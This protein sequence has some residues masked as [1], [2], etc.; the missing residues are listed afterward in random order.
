M[1]PHLYLEKSQDEGFDLQ[2]RRV[3]GREGVGLPFEFR[4]SAFSSSNV[5]SSQVLG[6]GATLVWESGFGSRALPGY[7]TRFSRRATADASAGRHY[8]LLFEP[9]L[10]NLRYTRR[11]RI[12]QKESIP[13][14]INEVLQP[15][16]ETAIEVKFDLKE[17]HE[18]EVYLVQYQETD[19]NFLS[20]ICREAAIYYEFQSREEDGTLKF[21]LVF[22]DRSAVTPLSIEDIYVSDA[23][24][25]ETQ[26]CIRHL[27]LSGVRRPGKVVA[28]AYVPENPRFAVE[29]E[30]R[31]DDASDLEKETRVYAPSQK[32]ADDHLGQL[33][34]QWLLRRKRARSRCLECETNQPMFAPGVAFSCGSSDTSA[35]APPDGEFVVSEVFHDWS[36]GADRYRMSLRAVPRNVSLIPLAPCVQPAIAGV[37]SAIVTGHPNEEIDPDEMGRVTVS[38]PWDQ[39]GKVDHTSSLPIRVLQPNMPGSMLIPRV[40]WE[41]LVGFEEGDP[42]RPLVLGRPYNAAQTPPYELPAHKDYSVIR[43]FTTPGGSGMNSQHMCDTKGSEHLMLSACYGAFLNVGNDSNSSV[44]KKEEV[45]C[46]T[47]ECLVSINDKESVTDA[48]IIKASSETIKVGGMHQIFAKGSVDANVGSES[49]AIGGALLE[50]IGNPVSGALNLGAQVAVALVGLGAGKLTNNLLGRFGPGKTLWQMASRKVAGKVAG[51]VTPIAGAYLQGANQG[52]AEQTAGT[53]QAGG[54]GSGGGGWSAMAKAGVGQLAGLLPGGDALLKAAEST[55]PHVSDNGSLYPWEDPPAAGGSQGTG[56]GAGAGTGATGGPIGPGPGHKIEKVSSGG[57]AEVIGASHAIVTPGSMAWE[58]TAASAMTVAGGQ[59]MTTLSYG[60]TVGGS[61]TEQSGSYT[62]KTTKDV[63]RSIKG[64]VKTTVGG[65]A[66]CK[67]GAKHTCDSKNMTIKGAEMKLDGGYIVFH[68]GSAFL[69]LSN[70]GMIYKGDISIS[71]KLTQSKSS[72]HQ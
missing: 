7:I 44:A 25:N 34:A 61:C 33:R 18:E 63:S 22:R 60:V 65:D 62:L 31:A 20:R 13:A 43:T 6:H 58:A 10:A 67:A 41:V 56:G 70:K 59:K 64:S 9:I 1:L 2:L 47:H 35:D 17:T 14:I 15:V 40:G 50:A 24:G 53:S 23:E 5:K 51:M 3:S 12:F 68:T 48:F 27:R 72:N 26:A 42:D 57:Y 71:G 69:V 19:L 36:Q 11:S 49:V 21:E 38:F 32:L 39:S 30:A 28:R 45:T 46:N 29:G 16:S 37:Q 66:F 52:W 54:G 4:L 8:E 55:A